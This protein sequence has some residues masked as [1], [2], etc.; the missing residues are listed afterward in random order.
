MAGEQ[1]RQLARSDAQ[2][3]RQVFN[4]GML[5]IERALI[6]DQ[7]QRPV[8]CR[9]GAFPR[10]TER[11][12]FRPATKTGPEA[13]QFGCGGGWKVADVCGSGLGRAHGPAI[14]FRRADRGEEPP[15]ISRVACD[16]RPVTLGKL[17]RHG[18]MK[19]SSL[20]CFGRDRPDDDV[21]IRRA[22]S[23]REFYGGA[24]HAQFNREKTMTGR[25]ASKTYG[26]VAADR[27][28]ELSGLEFVQ[29]LAEGTLPLNTIARTLGYDV[30]EAESGR[31]VVTAEPNDSHLNPAGTVHGGLAAT[32][33]DSCMGLAIQST[34]DKGIGSTTLEFKI[35]FIRP[36]TPATGPIRAEGI[37]INR[38]RRIG[39]AEGRVTDSKGRLLVHGTTTCLIFES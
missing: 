10:R 11:R 33:L 38:G 23:G 22:R 12:G 13:R 30:T 27:Q 14:D 26:T 16:A 7:P 21:R 24:P 28:R 19:S 4:A 18:T 9:A 31:V 25:A 29:G 35:S 5:R 34:L 6:H 37:V 2:L 32:M 1:P 20:R 39:I 15:V 8:D 3:R 17:Q 36:I